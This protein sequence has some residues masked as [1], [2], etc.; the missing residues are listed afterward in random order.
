MERGWGDAGWVD[1]GRGG[2][3]VMGRCWHCVGAES[4]MIARMRMRRGWGVRKRFV[5]LD[6]ATVNQVT[7]FRGTVE[8]ESGLI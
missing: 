1:E 4:R 6:I 7:T 5:G 8:F 2:R 3:I